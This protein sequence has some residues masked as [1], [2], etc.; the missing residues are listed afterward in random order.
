LLADVCLLPTIFL[1]SENSSSDDTEEITNY[2]ERQLVEKNKPTRI[3]S[4]EILVRY[5]SPRFEKFEGSVGT[6]VFKKVLYY[7]DQKNFSRHYLDIHKV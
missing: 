3:E 6:V 5:L 1:D 4:F 2:I 7:G